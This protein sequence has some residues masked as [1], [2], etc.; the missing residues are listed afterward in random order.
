L[1]TLLNEGPKNNASSVLA[2]INLNNNIRQG[3]LGSITPGH[4]PM[5]SM[6][7]PGGVAPLSMAGSFAPGGTKI[8]SLT[9]GGGL[10]A[11]G[12][13]CLPSLPIKN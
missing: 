2:G 4:R 10:K 3:D 1:N 12:E 13:G 7:T 6:N 5:K 9:P 8:S 11:N